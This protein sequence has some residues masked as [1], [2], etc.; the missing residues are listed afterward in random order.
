MSEIERIG[1]D[2][3]DAAPVHTFDFHGD[4]VHLVDISGKPHIVLRSA[5][6]TL[7]LSYS[8]QFRKLESR[9]WAT[10]ALAATVGAD[11]RAREMVV[12]DVRTFL[13]LLA[14]VDENRVAEHVR[15]KLIEYQ[16][17]I[18]DAIE[19]Y[20]T[21]GRAFN[22]RV[23]APYEPI[24]FTWAEM[25]AVIR[26]RHGLNMSVVVLMRT[27]R[28]AGV[29]LQ[30]GTPSKAFATSFCFSG[31]AWLVS[32]SAVA[33]IATKAYDAFTRLEAQGFV[34]S[35]LQVAPPGIADQSELDVGGAA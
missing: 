13:M 2:A 3:S 25:A 23:V 34:Q 35:R 27:L 22:P 33:L 30:N 21:E 14:T 16:A 7:G 20:W 10:V 19:A 24:A 32:P 5:I 15:P 18:A 12:V 17:E 11:G 26:Q 31:S 1:D 29:L 4:P 8:R 28:A 9:S 6:D